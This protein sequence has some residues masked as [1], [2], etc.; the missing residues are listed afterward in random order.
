M[1][2]T[3]PSIPDDSLE[4]TDQVPTFPIH[5]DVDD[6]PVTRVRAMPQAKRGPSAAPM[7]D[8]SAFAKAATFTW[9]LTSARMSPA[10]RLPRGN[11]ADNPLRAL[12][13]AHPS[14]EA[15]VSDPIAPAVEE[16]LPAAVQISE[17]VDTSPAASADDSAAVETIGAPCAVES[18]TEP[19]AETRSASDSAAIDLGVPSPAFGASMLKAR[20]K[21]AKR[22]EP[23]AELPSSDLSAAPTTF[24]SG[25]LRARQRRAR[26]SVVL[27]VLTALA[28]V[29]IAYLAM[30]S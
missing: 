22:R 8:R 18:P 25:M 13:F 15:P 17:L 5:V 21:G 9:P 28:A 29:V 24:G 4:S 7:R 11:P 30:R 20:A 26:P 27:L 19:T 2:S 16:R 10:G 1:E 14:E 3:D 12:A 23:R 6:E